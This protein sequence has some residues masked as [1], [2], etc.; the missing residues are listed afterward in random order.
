M[1]VLNQTIK[2]EEKFYNESTIID[3]HNKNIYDWDKKLTQNEIF[4]LRGV[5]NGKPLGENS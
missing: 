3:L 4:K 5:G 2:E 1:A